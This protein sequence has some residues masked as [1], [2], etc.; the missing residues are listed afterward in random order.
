MYVQY[1][2][3][4][5]T[6]CIPLNA[7]VFIDQNFKLP[8]K[9]VIDQYPSGSIQSLEILW[10]PGIMPIEHRPKFNSIASSL[11]A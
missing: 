9:S 7:N 6:K 8:I 5:K 1:F 3:G 4:L 11:H 2:S 10:I